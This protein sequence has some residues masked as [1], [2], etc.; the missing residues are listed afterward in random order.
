MQIR[1]ADI[2]IY[3]S[4]IQ[5]HASRGQGFHSGPPPLSLTFSAAL[6]FSLLTLTLFLL[7]FLT[8]A[9]L[10]AFT[11][12]LQ[13][14]YSFFA[15]QILLF[16]L[17]LFLLNLHCLLLTVFLLLLTALLYKHFYFAYSN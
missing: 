4:I 12:N 7:L 17:L 15:L 2:L 5:I 1:A 6:L 3:A 11:L 13:L 9:L 16:S 8:L 14:Y 10:S